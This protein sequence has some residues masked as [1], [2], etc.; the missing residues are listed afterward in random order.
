MKQTILV[1]LAAFFLMALKAGDRVP[2]FSAKN[3]NGVTVD[4][5]KTI[6]GK[7][8]LLYFYPKDDTSGCTKEA[9]QLKEIYPKFLALGAQVYGVS[10]QGEKS[11]QAF[12]KKYGLP[13]DLL[14][15]ENGKLADQLGV[16]SM[17]ILGLHKRQSL[18]IGADGRLVRFYENVDPATHAETVLSDIK[19]LTK[20]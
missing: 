11:H 13:F 14:V 20:K 17:P 18:L 12:I 5:S 9:N 19:K 10:R 1:F 6:K 15:D 3:Q 4:F 16:G 2:N 8:T 7:P